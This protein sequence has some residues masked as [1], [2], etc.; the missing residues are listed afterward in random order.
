[1]ETVQ[2]VGSRVRMNISQTAKGLCQVDCTAEFPTVEEA[3]DNLARAITEARA[4]IKEQGLE[5]AHA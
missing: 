5:E 4:V 3:R 2:E 1:M